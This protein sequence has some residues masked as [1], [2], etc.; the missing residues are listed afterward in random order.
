LR[1]CREV[2]FFGDGYE[3]AQLAQA[4]VF[5]FYMKTLRKYIFDQRLRGSV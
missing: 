1:G 5:D 2:Q 3:V 4:Y